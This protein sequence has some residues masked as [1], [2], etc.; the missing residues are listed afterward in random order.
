MVGTLKLLG[1]YMYGGKPAV[2]ALLDK[3]HA[4]QAPRVDIPQTPIL[5]LGTVDVPISVSV[6]APQFV[7]P[8]TQNMQATVHFSYSI[9]RATGE[10]GVNVE[11]SGI[12]SDAMAVA[13]L[14]PYYHEHAVPWVMGGAW[15]LITPIRLTA[16]K[17]DLPY[18]FVEHLETDW[19]G[20]VIRVRKHSP[21]GSPTPITP[22]DG[23]SNV[24][25]LRPV[26]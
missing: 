23:K 8:N 18:D 12:A 25:L 4:Q 10:R 26:P 15:D 21:L 16:D 3:E 22:L 14:L 11:L 24:T 5:I 19:E 1:A 9:H 17:K 7:R 20:L 2:K 13:K 6:N